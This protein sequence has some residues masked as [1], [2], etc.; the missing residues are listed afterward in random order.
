MLLK[1]SFW[2]IEQIFS[3]ALVRWSEN[4]VGGTRDQ[5]NFQPAAFASSL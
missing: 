4:A 5:S 1:K 3:E 2:G